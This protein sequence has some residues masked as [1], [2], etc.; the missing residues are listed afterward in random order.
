[1]KY[2]LII[3]LADCVPSKV[4]LKTTLENNEDAMSWA[5]SVYEANAMII[6]AKL[7]DDTGFGY[8]AEYGAA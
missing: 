7:Q 3:K 8:V 2:Q 5:K 4:V 1:M 6:S